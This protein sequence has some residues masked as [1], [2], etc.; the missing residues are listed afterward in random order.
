M[1]VISCNHSGNADLDHWEFNGYELL[2]NDREEKGIYLDLFNNSLIIRAAKKAVHDGNYTCVFSNKEFGVIYVRVKPDIVLESKDFVLGTN[3]INI[4]NGSTLSLMCRSKANESIA[5]ISWY[6][7]PEDESDLP[8]PLKPNPY[9][10][11]AINETVT[12][13][14]SSASLLTISPVSYDNRAFYICEVDNGVSSNRIRILLR[15]KDNLAAFWF[16]WSIVAVVVCAILFI[17][18][19]KRRK[20]PLEEEEEEEE[21][22]EDSPEKTD[23]DTFDTSSESKALIVNCPLHG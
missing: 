14:G 20:D 10:N 4:V 5:K 23:I 17:Y 9:N 13:Y 16:F 12:E 15:V 19:K 21:A 3:S 1:L 22:N 2:P 8:I 7:Q 18:E 6:I 11:V